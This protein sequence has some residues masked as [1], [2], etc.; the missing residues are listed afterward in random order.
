M[1]VAQIVAATVEAPGQAAGY[2]QARGSG[3]RPGGGQGQETGECQLP[4]HE[5]VQLPM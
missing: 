2:C 3:W 4:L 1:G 5:A